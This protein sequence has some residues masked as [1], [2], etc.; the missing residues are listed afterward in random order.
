MPQDYSANAVELLSE[1][2]VGIGLSEPRLVDPP[3]QLA[4]PRHR[5]AQA[6]RSRPVRSPRKKTSHSV[7]PVA[8]IIAGQQTSYIGDI[9]PSRVRVSVDF[10]NDRAEL[11]WERTAPRPIRTIHRRKTWTQPMRR[12]G[13]WL[14]IIITTTFCQ[15]GQGGPADAALSPL[16]VLLEEMCSGD[17]Y[18]RGDDG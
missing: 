11:A 8:S 16:V 2:A 18:W 17:F 4:R 12:A 13:V 6:R 3:I 10:H 1:S 9:S 14:T 15:G 5:S 7:S